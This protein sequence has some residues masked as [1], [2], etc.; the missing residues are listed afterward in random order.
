MRYKEQELIIP[1][2]EALIGA[3]N[4]K[5]PFSAEEQAIIHKYYGKVPTRELAKT[6]SDRSGARRTPAAVYRYAQREGL[7]FA[8]P[9]KERG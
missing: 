9:I 8:R 1:E 5:K 4:M 7:S 2:L 3:A 6:L